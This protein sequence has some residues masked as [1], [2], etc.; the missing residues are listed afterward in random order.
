MPGHLPSLELWARSARCELEVGAVVSEELVLTPCPHWV[1]H[2]RLLL[3]SMSWTDL[4]S[5]GLSGVAAGDSCTEVSGLPTLGACVGGQSSC[6]SARGLLPLT[7]RVLGTEG[8]TQKETEGRKASST[9][10]T[11]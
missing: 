11:Q 8:P 3:V 4:R 7:W 6:V 10:R 5:R 1:L 2:A 9:H